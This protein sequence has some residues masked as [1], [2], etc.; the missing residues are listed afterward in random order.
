[1]WEIEKKELI[2]TAL[3]LVQ[4]GLVSGTAG[5]VS[6]RLRDGQNNEYIVITPSSYHYDLIKTDDM[7]VINLEGKQIEGILKP[8]TELSLHRAIYKKKD[9]INAVIH[10]HSIYAT[11]MAVAGLN[12]PPVLDDQII[13]LGG[14]IKVSRHALPGTDDMAKEVVSALGDKKAMLMANHGALAIGNT[15]R[16]ALD[17]CQLLERL[18]NI[19]I[20]ASQVYLYNL[21]MK[22]IKK[23]SPALIEKE[24][25]LYDAG[26]KK[27]IRH[28]YI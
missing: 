27:G 11:A 24:L 8:S 7:A 22:K 12:I 15:L 1:M 2:E 21:G 26:E 6:V 23:I 5:N 18:A 10:T 3:K 25:A 13:Y 20:H 16:E 14:E 4:T 28:K 9:N 19:Y 17:N